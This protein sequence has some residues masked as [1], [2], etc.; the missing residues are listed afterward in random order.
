MTEKK[1]KIN[2]AQGINLICEIM[3]IIGE[4]WRVILQRKQ[5]DEFA[6]ESPKTDAEEAVTE[7]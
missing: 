6:R 1:L 4:A 3:H 2:T 7:M 5:V